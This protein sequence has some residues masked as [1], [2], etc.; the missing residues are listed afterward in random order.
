VDNDKP[1]KSASKA[2][3]KAY[4]IAQGMSEDEA[5]ATSRDNLAAQYA[6]EDGADDQAQPTPEDAAKAAYE[7][8]EAMTSKDAPAPV[9]AG[10][11]ELPPHLRA[12][13][14]HRKITTDK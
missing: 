7:A 10:A 14:V 9:R 2:D 4:A 3:W 13:A 8:G 12:A 5:E 11:E 6:D 1:T